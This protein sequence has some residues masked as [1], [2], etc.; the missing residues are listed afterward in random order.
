MPDQWTVNQKISLHL[1]YPLSEKQEKVASEV[2]ECVTE[3]KNVL[4][5]AVTGAGKTELVY[6]SMEYILKKGG[7]VGFSTPRKDVVIDLLP[8]IKTAF[9]MAKCVAVYGQHTSVL[10]GDIIVLTTH[11][12]YRYGN[13]FDLLILDEIDAF[14]Y[15]GNTLLQNFFR[16]SIK[17]NY[18][19]LSATPSEEDISSIKKDNG[20][21]VT[22]FERYHHSPLPVPEFIQTNPLTSYIV[23]SS[24]LR[25]FLKDKKPVFVFVPTIEEGK[26]LYAFLSV[27]NINGGFVSSK[28]NERKTDVQ[29]FKE[30]KLSYLVTTSILE[31]GVTVRNLQVIVFH[32]DSEIYNESTLVQIAGR[33]GRKIDASTGQVYFL[34]YEKNESIVKAINQIKKYNRKAGLS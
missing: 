17:G 18:V 26:K 3:G 16:K 9:P 29:K 8:R 28:E 14:P 15:R 19:L 31:R 11:Q 12:L 23:C 5:H 2:L 4:I 30:G 20:K 21:V 33:V 6:Y 24:Y 32:S 22:L 7:H 27:L 1:D 34:G 13:F 10:L 25:R